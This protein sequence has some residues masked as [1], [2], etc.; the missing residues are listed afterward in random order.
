MEMNLEALSSKLDRNNPVRLEIHF[1][2]NI[3]CSQ[4]STWRPQCGKVGDTFGGRHQVGVTLL[5]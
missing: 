5:V 4:R 3:K 1:D 2:A